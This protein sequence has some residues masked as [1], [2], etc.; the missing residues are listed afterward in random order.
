ME[1]ILILLLLTLFA[2][3]LYVGFQ[4]C[5]WVF[6]SRV[7][8]NILLI[9]LGVGISGLGIHHL[10]FKNMH[11]IQSDVYP[12]LYLVKYPVQ[13]QATLRQAIR[14]QLTTHLGLAFPGGKK[15]NYQND[16]SVFFYAY[17]KAWPISVFQD[18]GTAYFLDHEEDL[19]GLVT[20]ELGMYLKYQLAEF[21]YVPCQ[22]GERKYCGE[23]QFYIDA[24]PHD[25]ERL[26]GLP[27]PASSAQH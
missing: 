19:G 27:A 12:D 24:E 16:D 8:L 20:E 11:F 13:D 7:R 14:E 17:Y 2:S 22:A 3:L 10:F 4:L 25:S 18:E 21:K 9:T 26:S 15:L 6:S 23:I 5:K 1:I